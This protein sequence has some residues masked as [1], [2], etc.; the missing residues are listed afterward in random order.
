MHKKK[1]YLVLALFILLLNRNSLHAKNKIYSDK[2]IKNE[3]RLN[4]DYFKQKNLFTKQLVFSN[5]HLIKKFKMQYLNKNGL[6]YL[7]KVM[8]RSLLYRDFI[9]EQ[10][11]VHALPNELLF[12]PVIESGFNEKAV[13]RSGAT[14]IWQ[15]MK[16]SVGGYNITI[17]EWLDERHDPWK[18]SIAAIKK[19]QYNFSVLGDW[20]LAL[21]AYNAGLNSIQKAIKR[22]GSKDFWYLL[23]KGYLKKETA[24]YVPKFLAITEILMQ[25]NKYGIDW[26]NRENTITTA[27]VKVSQA[28]DITLLENELFLKKG[29]LRFLNPSL[30]YSITP[31]DQAY[32]LRVPSEYSIK[33]QSIVASGK[34]LVKYYIH[35]VKSGDTLYALSRYYGI[36]VASIRNCNKGLKPDY[37]RIGQKILVPALKKPAGIAQNNKTQSSAHFNSLYTIK[38]GDT[39]WSIALTHNTTVEMLAEKNNMQI[40][41]I[42]KVGSTIRLPAN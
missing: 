41:A 33:L 14:G 21:A 23:D 35:T 13:S 29:I 19:L 9:L 6:D 7:S 15:F 38:K 26:G 12:L 36:S 2:H 37:L 1:K 42:L 25:S 24:L 5:H 18:T 39:L 17:S 11:E 34:I 32:D 22:A 10:L 16:N 28:I 40:D 4:F 20:C 27:T 8:Q 3:D 31:P 30:R